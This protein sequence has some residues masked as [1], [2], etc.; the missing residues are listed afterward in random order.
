M[1]EQMVAISRRSLAGIGLAL[2]L[3]LGLVQTAQALTAG[4]D[5]DVVVYKVNSDGSTT[6]VSSTSATADSSGKIEFGLSAL[7]TADEANFIFIEIK[8]ASDTVVRRAFA[9]APPAGSTNLVGVNEV[10]DIQAQ[11]IRTSMADNA[12]DDPMGV[13]FGLVFVRSPNLTSADIDILA[14]MMGAAI[15]PGNGGMED[16]LLNNGVSQSQ[17]DTFK[18]R[19]VAN[20]AADTN[21]LADYMAFFKTA[22]DNANDDEMAKA[23]S[24]MAEVFMDAAVAADIEP[25]LIMMAFNA[26]GS[27]PGLQ[28]LMQSLSSDFAAAIEQAVQGFF[29]RIGASKLKQEYSLALTTLNASG[30]EVDR[31]NAAVQSFLADQQA[32]DVQYAGFFMNPAGYAASVGKTEQQIRNE[33]DQAF[34]NAWQTLRTNLASTNAEITAMRTKVE[35][36]LGLNPG[37]LQGVVGQEYD[38][39]G[40]LVNWPIPQTVSVAWVADLIAA[41]GGFTYTRDTLAVPDNMKQWLDSDDDPNNGSDGQRHDFTDPSFGMP[42]DF[43]A[44]MGLMEDVQIVEH[45]LYA[46]WDNGQPTPAQEQAA[47]KAYLQNLADLVSNIGGTTDG[48]TLLSTAEKESLVKLMQEPELR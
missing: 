7:P 40:N 35:N 29:T 9:P 22:V 46:T 33:L 19:I 24:V 39:N 21:D 17:L 11:A 28:T 38:A 45:T 34:M 8:D 30:S 13:A 43:A 16:F 10:S 18:S 47:H 20:S 15:L 5:Y 6:S 12:T 2:G 36:A 27:A 31:F 25:G 41:G 3:A 1:F 23:G 42:A 26:A 4:A 32:I 37:D 44:L 14:D 48:S